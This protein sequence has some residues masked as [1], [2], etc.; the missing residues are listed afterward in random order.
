M[1]TQVTSSEHTFDK[2]RMMAHPHLG[3]WIQEGCLRL[4][5]QLPRLLGKLGQ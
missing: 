3:K 5:V 1:K 4:T 2:L